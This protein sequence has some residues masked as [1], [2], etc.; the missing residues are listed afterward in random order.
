MYIF[1]DIGICEFVYLGHVLTLTVLTW[2]WMH[3]VG[4]TCISKHI[5]QMWMQIGLWLR[6]DGRKHLQTITVTLF[7]LYSHSLYLQLQYSK[8]I[9]SQLLAQYTEFQKI[10]NSKLYSFQRW[11]Q[12][13]SSI[14]PATFTCLL[15]Y[16]FFKLFR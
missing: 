3:M 12:A 10:P 2:K 6:T 15:I 9:I 11:K 8:W 4:N 1:S 16:L 7:S 5:M 13:F 14:L